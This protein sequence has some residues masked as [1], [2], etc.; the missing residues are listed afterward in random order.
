MIFSDI[1]SAIIKR[2]VD[3]GEFGLDTIYPNKDRRPTG[4]REHAR[5]WYMPNGVSAPGVG[6]QGYDEHQGLVQIDLAYPTNEGIGEMMEKADEI[7][8]HFQSGVRA[9]Y[10]GQDV[11]VRGS[12]ISPPINED[13]WIKASVTIDYSAYVR[14]TL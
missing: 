4:G 7:A 2:Y 8:R 12:E 3:A 6:R 14:R 9:E 10:N 1:Y 11:V 13:G 5:I